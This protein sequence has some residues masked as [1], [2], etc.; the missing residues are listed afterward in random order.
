MI[1]SLSVLSVETSPF[2]FRVHLSGLPS[3]G[4]HRVG[5]DWSDLAAAAAYKAQ[6]PR[7]FPDVGFLVLKPG[8]PRANQDPGHPS[9][10]YRLPQSW[11][12]PLVCPTPCLLSNTPHPPFLL[13]HHFCCPQG[14]VYSSCLG[15]LGLPR[16][17]WTESESVSRSVMSWLFCD[18]MDCS[19]PGSSVHGNPRREYWY[20]C[21]PPGDLPD[22][23]I[24]PRSPALQ[25]KSLP[26]ESPGVLVE[27]NP[28]PVQE[29]QEMWVRSLGLEKEMATHSSILVWRIPSIE[30]PG[31]LQSKGSQRAEHDQVT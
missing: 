18:P 31:G 5:H 15:A 2:S 13:A 19:P 12:L 25:V 16:R 17:H 9:S 1:L 22:L 29:T 11:M 4:S 30:E 8:Q 27:K 7:A 28:L 23:G 3:M 24:E 14:V 10:V 26:S 20:L 21:P 6:R